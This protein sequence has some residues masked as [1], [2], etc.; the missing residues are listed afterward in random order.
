MKHLSN[1]NKVD[2]LDGELLARAVEQDHTELTHGVYVCGG[3]E[4][5]TRKVL[6]PHMK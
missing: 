3:G 5:L 2:P 4:Q 1:E 6:L